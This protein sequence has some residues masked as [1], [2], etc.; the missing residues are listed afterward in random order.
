MLRFGFVLL[1]T[2]LPL[3]GMEAM[4]TRRETTKQVFDAATK[5][6]DA[7]QRWRHREEQFSDLITAA[8]PLSTQARPVQT[9]IRSCEADLNRALILG[10]RY[11]VVAGVHYNKT[12]RSL[13]RPIQRT[14]PYLLPDGKT[15]D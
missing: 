3:L 12:L 5:A 14:F 11:G 9:N 10:R 7:C 1:M 15:G 4:S 2:A 6:L 8:K 13:H